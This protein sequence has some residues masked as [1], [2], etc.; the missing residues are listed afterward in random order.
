MCVN[1]TRPEKDRERLAV[2]DNI[3]MAVR[4]NDL[5]RVVEIGDPLVSEEKRKRIILRFDSKRHG[6][7]ARMKAYIAVRLA[8]RVTLKINRNTE[9]AGLENITGIK[10]AAIITSNHFNP[11]DS[12]VIRY[13][14]MKIGREMELDIV[15][16]ESNVFMKGFFGF[17]MRNCNTIPVS[18]DIGYM[19]KSFKSSLAEKMEKGRLVLIYPEAEMWWNYR[20]P[21]DLKA[22]AYHYAVDHGV[23]V[24]P[25][26][27]EMRETDGYD[28][29]G[30][31][32]VKYILHIM[33]PIYPDL[34]LPKREAREKMRMADLEAKRQCYEA[35][36]KIPLDDVFIPE[37][38]IAGE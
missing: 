35:V 17:L 38:D 13:M 19:A 16:K 25:C 24:I 33:P 37:R 9:I 7:I 31:K 27:T 11:A 12:T 8:E 2:I 10:G 26:F 36:Y 21:R 23:P 28:D 29:K 20:K 4:D 30:F 14:L 5:F 1:A 3:A 18:Q 15:I 32:N 22:G 34:Y 6:P